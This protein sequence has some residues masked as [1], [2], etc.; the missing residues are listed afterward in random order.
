MLARLTTVSL[1]DD[2][3][4]AHVEIYGSVG[5]DEGLYTV[6]V[7]NDNSLIFN[8]TNSQ[9]TSALLYQD[10]SIVPGKHTVKISNSPFTGQTLRIDYAIIYSHSS[11]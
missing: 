2:Q 4:G 11:K 7:D 3:T 5:P 9:L 10:N 6:Q 1:S 8:A